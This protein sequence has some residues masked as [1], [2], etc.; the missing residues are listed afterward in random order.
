MNNNTKY[1]NYKKQS[2]MRAS[3]FSMESNKLKL[4]ELIKSI[5]E[6]IE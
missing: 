1:E 3:D 4:R 6:N 2:L 5:N